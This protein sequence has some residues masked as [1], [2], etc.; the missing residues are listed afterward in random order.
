MGK[1]NANMLNK[2]IDDDV[3]NQFANMV[4]TK[5]NKSS[6][7]TETITRRQTN[8]ADITQKI[9]KSYPSITDLSSKIERILPYINHVCETND[10]GVCK[11]LESDQYKKKL[12]LVYNILASMGIDDA[13][14]FSLMSLSSSNN[15]NK[16]LIDELKLNAT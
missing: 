3:K 13:L 1:D 15:I 12:V 14:I 5:P 10:K 16:K 7:G 8:L 6:K 4:T 11:I 9:I 2:L